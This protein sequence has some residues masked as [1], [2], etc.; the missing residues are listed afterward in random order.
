MGPKA[1]M[2]RIL[3]VVRDLFSTVHLGGSILCCLSIIFTV[4]SIIWFLNLLCSNIGRI[5]FCTSETSLIFSDITMNSIMISLVTKRCSVIIPYIDRKLNCG[6]NPLVI[7]SY[8]LEQER[9]H[10]RGWGKGGRKGAMVGPLQFP[11][12]TRSNSFS[13]KHQRYCFL[14]VL[15]NYMNQK[16]H[17]FYRVCYNFW[18]I[19]GSFSFFLTA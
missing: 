13:F 16:F 11:N 1:L 10:R 9:N 15:R 12:Q 14:W 5:S 8:L 3:R 19:R 18:A 2:S 4:S 17:D 7:R 6:V